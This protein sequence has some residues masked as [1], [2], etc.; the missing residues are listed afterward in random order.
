MRLRTVQYNLPQTI[1]TDVHARSVQRVGN[2]RLIHLSL[3]GRLNWWPLC[4]SYSPIDGTRLQTNVRGQLSRRGVV[5]I[6]Q[7]IQQMSAR[8]TAAEGKKEAFVV[9]MKHVI[10][11]CNMPG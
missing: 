7:S 5:T 3:D 1:S 10:I 8:S 4:Y 6:T 11:L 9:C 2:E